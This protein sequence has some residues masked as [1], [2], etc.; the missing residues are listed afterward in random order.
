[1]GGAGGVAFRKAARL[2]S[3]HMKWPAGGQGKHILGCTPFEPAPRVAPPTPAFQRERNRN[4]TKAAPTTPRHTPC[5][6]RPRSGLAPR[7][8]VRRAAACTPNGM[9]PEQWRPARPRAA[10]NPWYVARTSRPDERFRVPHQPLPLDESK[11]SA[12]EV[13]PLALLRAEHG[14]AF[15]PTDRRRFN[16][17][18]SAPGSH[19]R[20]T[21]N[22]MDDRD[23][24]REAE[25]AFASLADAVSAASTGGVSC[26]ATS[27]SALALRG[28]SPRA[29]RRRLTGDRPWFRP[30]FRSLRLRRR[31]LCV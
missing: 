10:N 31:L 11:S 18:M 2:E 7:L 27:A 12:G 19:D 21:R 29:L 30:E 3:R 22:P 23:T 8:A 4:K 20:Q 14:D 17:I 1:M 9:S 26:G 28:F 5:S 25:P 13:R 16:H 15:K 24:S 6:P